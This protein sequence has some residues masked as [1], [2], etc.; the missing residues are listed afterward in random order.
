L[1]S[2]ELIAGLLPGLSLGILLYRF[3]RHQPARP[4]DRL[5][6]G[7]ASRSHRNNGVPEAPGHGGLR[8][9]IVL[10]SADRIRDVGLLAKDELELRRIRNRQGC[11]RPGG[12][13]ESRPAEIALSIRQY[14][15]TGVF[16][17][18]I[19]HPVFNLLDDI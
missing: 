6:K 13:A 14:T 11:L 19:P 12:Q 17:A 9:R 5:L 18:D 10:E 4:R 16:G 8:I 1:Y 3:G 7:A 2:D 15:A